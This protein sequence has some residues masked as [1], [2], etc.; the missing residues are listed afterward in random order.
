MSL[1]PVSLIKTEFIVTEKTWRHHFLNYK[2]MGKN[3]HSKAKDS[4]VNNPI[5]P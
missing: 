5:Q 1:L 4:K 2:S 3:P